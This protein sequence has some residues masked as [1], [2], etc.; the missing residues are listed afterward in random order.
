MQAMTISQLL[1]LTKAE[2][3]SIRD[4]LDRSLPTL[5]AGS[6]ERGAVVETLRNIEAVLVRPEFQP[7]RPRFTPAQ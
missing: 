3:L 5:P 2:I 7:R 6:E 4:H 1:Q